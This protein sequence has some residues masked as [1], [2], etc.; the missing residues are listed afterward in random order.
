M[1]THDRVDQLLAGFALGG[2][3]DGDA[4]RVRRHL[5]ECDVCAA[6]LAAMA[7]VVGALPLTIELSEPSPM[8][9]QRVA[10]IA[11][12]KRRVLPL[13]PRPPRPLIRLPLRARPLPWSWAA[14]AAIAVALLAWNVALQRQLNDVNTTV[15]QLSGQTLRGSLVGSG[16][17][18]AGSASYFSRDGVTLVSL[19]GVAAPAADHEYE[20][21]VITAAGAPAPAGSFLPEVD[22]TKLIVLTRPM[23][24]GS[25]LAVTV[26]PHGVAHTAPTT[27]PLITGRLT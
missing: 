9:R 1:N 15:A 14:A 22:G 12:T 25:R 13:L 2:I 4:G 23:V 20:L 18:P 5:K 24:P 8:L 6:N 11:Q 21:W 17:S 19:R 10:A 3:S 16:G 27:V 7:D 26:E